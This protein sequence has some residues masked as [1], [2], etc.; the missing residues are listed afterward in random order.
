MGLEFHSLSSF[1]NSSQHYNKDVSPESF[2]GL[3]DIRHQSTPT[4]NFDVKLS[5]V[6]DWHDKA[7]RKIEVKPWGGH[8]S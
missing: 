2:I 3:G 5:V 4:S 8:S 7:Q 6:F 1:V